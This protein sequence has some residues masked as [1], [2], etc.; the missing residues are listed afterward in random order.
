MNEVNL[1]W[2]E[3]AEMT[4][5]TPKWAEGKPGVFAITHGKLTVYIGKAQYHNSVF[6]EAKNRENKWIRQFKAHS[7]LSEDMRT[8][9]ARTYVDTHCRIHVALIDEKQRDLIGPIEDILISR[10]QKQLICNTQIKSEDKLR[11]DIKII[12]SGNLPSGI[13]KEM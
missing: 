12:N 1:F 7:I 2:R 6:K 5:E 9:D 10:L 3:P 11:K 13:T 4:K 8:E